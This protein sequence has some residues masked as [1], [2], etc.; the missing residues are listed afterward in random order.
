MLCRLFINELVV[1]YMD[2]IRRHYNFF[3]WVQ[4]VGFRYT[5]Q[6]AA[7]AHGVT[8]WVRNE[9]DGSVTMEIQGS[10][11]QIDKVVQAINNARYISIEK[12][13][14]RDTAV[15]PDETKFRVRY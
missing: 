12:T 8:G 9:Y 6:Y 11:E 14:C 5:A 2:M 15:V 1:Y 13:L 7:N 3:G 10:E 4:G